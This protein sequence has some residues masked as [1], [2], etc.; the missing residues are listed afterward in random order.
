LK[1]NLQRLKDYKKAV[2]EDVENL[3]ECHQILEKLH[4]KRVRHEK[5]AKLAGAITALV[6]TAILTLAAGLNPKTWPLLVPILKIGGSSGVLGGGGIA[7]GSEYKIEFG[8]LQ[9]RG[10]SL[11]KLHQD[12]EKFNSSTNQ[13]I[14]A[15][16]QKIQNELRTLQGGP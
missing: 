8:S 2:R 15:D 9:Q 4:K 5:G 3:R 1:K 13:R 16:I 11:Q 6:A 12:L 14:D 10:K 7:A